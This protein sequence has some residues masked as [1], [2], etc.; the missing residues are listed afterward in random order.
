[1]SSTAHTHSG[2]ALAR[3]DPSRTSTLR[4]RYAQKLRGRFGELNTAIR[5]GI[6][7]RDVFGLGG[8]LLQ[9]APIDDVPPF[10]FETDGRKHE[11]FMSWLRRQLERGVL[12]VIARNENVYIQDA[13]R[14]GLQ[15]AER[16][17]RKAGHP[18]GE[19][20]IETTFNLPV[21][22]ESVALLYTRNYEALDGITQEVAKQI[23]RT[24]SEGFVEGKNPRTIARELSDRVDSI[25]KT[26][27]TVLARTEVI[28]THA[29]STLERYEQAGVD[30]VSGKAE[31]RTAGDR[32]VCSICRSLNGN[33]YTIAEAKGLIPVHPQCRCVWLP[34]V[35]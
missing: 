14:S 19:Q 35:S 2:E 1:M 7:E 21:H 3:T 8:E 15:H 29:T 12:R 30:E 24:L 9:A 16:E 13:Y 33:T 32:R 5:T 4:R 34:V 27:S 10:R 25:G 26:R 17:L 6:I 11:E 22:Q 20:D 18:I 31:L 28:N 23:S